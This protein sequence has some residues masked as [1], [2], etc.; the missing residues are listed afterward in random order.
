MSDFRQPVIGYLVKTFPK[1]SETFILNEI[2]ELE[3]QGV[4][5]HIFSLRSPKDA[6]HHPAVAQVKSPVTYIPSIL[7]E[8]NGVAKA[9]LLEAQVTLS[10]QFVSLHPN[11]VDAAIV[12]HHQRPEEKELNEIWQAIYLAQELQR[13]NI[14]H[15]H[16]HFA[17]VPTATAEMAQMICGVSYSMTA[18]AK[19][20]YLSDPNVL[21]RRIAKAEFVLTCTDFN[22]QYLQRVSRSD[23]AIHLAYH[24]IDLKRF[25][26]PS[27]TPSSTPVAQPVRLLSVGRF[28]EKKGFDYLLKACWLLWAHDLNFTCTLVGYG[29]L[30]SQIEQWIDDYQLNGIV[31]LAGKLTQD[32]VLE[33]YRQADA[34]VLPCVVTEDGDRDGIPNVLLEA[35]ATGLPVVSTDISGIGELVQSGHNGLLVPERDAV[36]LADALQ[37]LMADA[38]WRSQLGCNGQQT[39]RQR[40]ALTQNVGDVKKLLLK[41]LTRQTNQPSRRRASTHS[42][43]QY[44]DQLEAAL[45]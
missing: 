24:G 44:V 14:A 6:V 15:L 32:E 16:V 11:P 7:P 38:Q 12:F 19:D 28:C 8:D 26:S 27:A 39:V 35:M 21:D 10:Q 43:L 1:L 5:L 30:Q 41:A 31:T 45:S 36:A 23:T 9:A 13:L 40:F 17:N 33:Q 3:R 4:N 42:V 25:T 20:I 34:F 18:H 22:R 29:P 37:R 2:L